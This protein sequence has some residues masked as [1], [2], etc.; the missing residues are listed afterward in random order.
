MACIRQSSC[1][2]SPE[3]LI[4]QSQDGIFL[5][6]F[7]GQG[8]GKTARCVPSC[9]VLRCSIRITS[10]DESNNQ[11]SLFISCDSASERWKKKAL[12]HFPPPH[13]MAPGRDQWK[14]RW[15]INLTVKEPWTKSSCFLMDLCGYRKKGKSWVWKVLSQSE[16]NGLNQGSRVLVEGLG[17]HLSQG[18]LVV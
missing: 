16:K 3:S 2:K 10:Q 9:Q 14:H 1:F 18:G 4:E 15:E 8:T 7:K 13:V 12:P 17:K 5:Y 6:L 11:T